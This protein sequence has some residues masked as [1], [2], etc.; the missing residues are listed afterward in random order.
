MRFQT[1]AIL[2]AIVWSCVPGRA[3]EVSQTATPTVIR[4]ETRVVLVDSVVT[5]KKATT[6]PI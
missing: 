6:S 3:Q 2:T 1:A 5:D 4:T